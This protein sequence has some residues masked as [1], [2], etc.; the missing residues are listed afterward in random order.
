LIFNP[1][2]DEQIILFIRNNEEKNPVR[3]VKG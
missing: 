3:Q 1:L 2:P